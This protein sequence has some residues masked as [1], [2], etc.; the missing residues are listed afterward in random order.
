M[1]TQAADE[2]TG[3]EAGSRELQ[4]R[5]RA[6][7]DPGAPDPEEELSVEWGWHQHFPKARRVAGVL[8][9][10]A[11]LSMISVGGDFGFEDWMLILCGGALLLIVAHDTFVRRD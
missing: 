10:A 3:D 1:A 7:L 6:E 9:A 2:Q 8:T 11:L 4:L 5:E